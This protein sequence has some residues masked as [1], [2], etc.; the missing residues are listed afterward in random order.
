MTLLGKATR[1]EARKSSTVF[2]IVLQNLLRNTSII[3]LILYTSIEL[4]TTG[5]VEM[6]KTLF[7]D[8]WNCQY[9]K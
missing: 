1:S 7:L 8:L 6:N 9:S 4:G 2:L 3:M 5:E